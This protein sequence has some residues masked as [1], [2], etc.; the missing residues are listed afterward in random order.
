MLLLLWVMIFGGLSTRV[1]VFAPVVVAAVVTPLLDV[2][3]VDDTSA[4]ADFTIQ[5]RPSLV[6]F[7]PT[8]HLAD[9]GLVFLQIPDRSSWLKG[10]IFN[11]PSPSRRVP[12]AGH[13]KN[14]A[15][16]GVYILYRKLSPQPL[17]GWKSNKY[18]YVFKESTGFKYYYIYF[19][20][21]SQTTA[22][23]STV[24][25]TRGFHSSNCR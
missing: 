3:Y 13:F 8:R 21:T 20:F 17:T 9:I 22:I 5:I 4:D 14:A 1:V 2:V 23:K 24:I 18:C 6:S 19:Y 10:L 11:T 15:R 7:R 12:N 25:N 16:S